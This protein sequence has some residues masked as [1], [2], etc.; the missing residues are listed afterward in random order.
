M[1]VMVDSDRNS[2]CR[3]AFTLTQLQAD[4]TVV[5]GQNHAKVGM[6]E[7]ARCISAALLPHTSSQCR[8]ACPQQSVGC[9]PYVSLSYPCSTQKA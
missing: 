8:K 7:H 2:L 4:M 6:S 1:V 3:P 5:C 9:A